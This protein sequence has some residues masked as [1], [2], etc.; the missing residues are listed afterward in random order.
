[1]LEKDILVYH[2]GEISGI[3]AVKA[4]APRVILPAQLP[5]VVL[6][7]DTLETVERNGGMTVKYRTI[8]AVLFT[9]QVGFGT[10]TGGYVVTD[11]FFDAIDTYF[12]AR[13]TLAKADGTTELIHEYMGDEGETLTPYPTGSKE[14]GNFWTI[15]FNHR[16]TVIKPVTYQ[17]GV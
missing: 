15:T 12:E 6:F 11:P 17:S 7:A 2:Y 9:D 14:V 16:F 3:Q 13:P 5:L 4:Y 8:R 10:E 1:M